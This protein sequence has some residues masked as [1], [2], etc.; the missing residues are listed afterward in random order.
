M[1]CF[2]VNYYIL[3]VAANSPLRAYQIKGVEK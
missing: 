3:D 1:K 2:L